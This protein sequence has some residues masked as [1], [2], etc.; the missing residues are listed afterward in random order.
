MHFHYIKKHI[1]FF[2]SEGWSGEGCY[3]SSITSS[4]T[5]CVCNHLTHFAVLMDFT[6][7]SSEL[8]SLNVLL[9]M[10]IGIYFKNVSSESIHDDSHAFIP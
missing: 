10:F 8:V 3:A 9:W 2:S 6:D 1:F 4:E 7:T 5:V